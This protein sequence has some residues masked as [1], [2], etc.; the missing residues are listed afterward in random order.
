MNIWQAESRMC[1]IVSIK[2]AFLTCVSFLYNGGCVVASHF[3]FRNMRMTQ[4]ASAAGWP[5]EFT[6][7]KFA[8]EFK[9]NFQLRTFWHSGEYFH[10][11]V[12]QHES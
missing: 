2:N 11:V 4:P 10:L 3:N 8:P 12:S 5:V 1:C 7:L 6:A 9:N